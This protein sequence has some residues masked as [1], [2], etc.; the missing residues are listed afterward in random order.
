[1]YVPEGIFC[2]STIF[3]ISP[4]YVASVPNGYNPS[5]RTSICIALRSAPDSLSPLPRISWTVCVSSETIRSGL[6]SSPTIERSERRHVRATCSSLAVRRNTCKKAVSICIE[7]GL[8]NTVSD[9][10]A[11]KLIS[12]DALV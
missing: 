5:F 12:G 8:F 10:S 2:S 7:S 6:T 1:M 11:P 4:L 9:V 3:D